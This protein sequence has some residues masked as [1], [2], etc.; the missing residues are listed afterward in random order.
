MPRRSYSMFT[1]EVSSLTLASSS[2]NVPLLTCR[3]LELLG[4]TFVASRPVH[5]VHPCEQSSCYPATGNLLI[6][7]ENRLQASSTCGIDRPERYCIV[8]HLEEKKC[9]LCDTRPETANTP[10]KN[11]RVGQIIYKN[12]PGGRIEVLRFG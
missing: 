10:M 11:H 4:L 1:F 6:G 7:R 3:G 12:M 5:R 8:S 9:F 2:A